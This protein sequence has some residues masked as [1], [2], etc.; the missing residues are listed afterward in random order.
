[1][2]H[3]LKVWHAVSRQKSLQNIDRLQWMSAFWPS[4]LR[5]L[6]TF[7]PSLMP[8]STG[9]PGSV[10]RTASAVSRGLR[11]RW[12]QCLV[13]ILWH[14]LI[15][16]D[17]LARYFDMVFCTALLVDAT[18]CQWYDGHKRRLCLR[19]FTRGSPTVSRMLLA[20]EHARAL[21]RQS[22]WAVPTGKTPNRA[23]TSTR[24]LWIWGWRGMARAQGVWHLQASDKVVPVLG[25]HRCALG[26][27]VSQKSCL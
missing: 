4:V 14:K 17:W 7:S 23:S 5:S 24:R 22:L 2:W 15:Q 26:K 11:N 1:M 20:V 10:I 16:I 18:L 9:Q 13:S 8:R 12:Q 27:C 6:L 3:V 25:K 21:L 19:V